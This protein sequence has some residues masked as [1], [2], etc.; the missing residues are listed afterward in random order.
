MSKADDEYAFGL[1]P[2]GSGV[3]RN[4]LGLRDAES[5]KIAEYQITRTQS[6]NAP[7]FPMTQAGYQAL[8]KHLFSEVFEWAGELRTQDMSKPEAKFGL[9]R[10]MDVS[11]QT[12]FSALAQQDAL[13]GQTGERFA[14]GAAHHISEINTAHPFREGNGRTMRLHLQQLAEQ[15]GHRIDQPKMPAAE[16]LTAS[17]QAFRGDERPLA[18]IIAGA[19][20]PAR[21][22]S[23]EA[24]AAELRD[25][26]EP[27]RLAIL[28]A[29]R[30]VRER[31]SNSPAVDEI[32]KGY[33]LEFAQL[34]AANSFTERL[35]EFGSAST[36]LQVNAPASATARDRAH[37]L[38]GAAGRVP[39]SFVADAAGPD[40]SQAAQAPPPPADPIAAYFARTA[41]PAAP[42]TPGTE[43]A[44]PA[45][46]SPGAPKPSSPRPSKGASGPEPGF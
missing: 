31:M 24:A 35:A 2:D 14:D 10:F 38:L 11:M 45:P 37:A 30:S 17:I 36:L 42:A 6:L 18:A 16:W 26:L 23:P 33:R 27:A 40:S 44:P 22:L 21:L 9:A 32:V 1:Y 3:L 41:T 25:S 39:A 5:L 15:A 43:P 8:H 12:I 46:S 13:R 34:G 28:A 29:T 19:L 4:K 20:T 7:G